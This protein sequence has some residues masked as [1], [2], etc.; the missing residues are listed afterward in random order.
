MIACLAIPAFELRAALRKRPSVALQP[1]AV[2]P[3]TGGAAPGSCRKLI[4]GAPDP[5]AAERDW[6]KIVRSLKDSGFAVESSALGTAYFDTRGVE[7]LYGGLE[8]A[9]GRAPE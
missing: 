2:A 3:P 8:S 5:P 9:L 6:E 4:L 7:R 1:A